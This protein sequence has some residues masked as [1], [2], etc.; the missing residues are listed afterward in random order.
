[1]KKIIYLSLFLISCSSFGQTREI[2]ITIDDLPLVASKMDTP[3]NQQRSTERFNR[4]LN[5]LI[6]NQVPAT[7]FVIAGAIANGQ[8]AFLEQFRN[9]GFAI[10]SHTYSHFNLNRMSAEKYIADIERADKVLTPLFTQPKYFRYPYLAEGNKTTKPLVQEYLNQHNYVVAP[11]TI[12]SKDF[13]FNEQ[14]Y[15]V[16]FRSRENYVYKLKP[17]YLAYIWKQTLK[18]EKK[19]GDQ[20]VKQILLIHANLLNSYL[21]DDIIKMYK[22]NGYT[23]ITLTEALKNP[24]PTLNAPTKETPVDDTDGDDSIEYDEFAFI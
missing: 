15:K 20:P 24:A 13:Q 17:A 8:W 23:F 1:M 7:G 10:G 16:P 6:D 4:L 18:A 21:L 12:D 11:V 14:L 2:A 5:A 19:A 22:N 3:G 9:A